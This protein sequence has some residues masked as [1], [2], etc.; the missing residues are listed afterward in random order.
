M[1]LGVPRQHSLFLA[2]CQIVHDLYY[3]GSRVLSVFKLK[4]AP[5]P[6]GRDCWGRVAATGNV[7]QPRGQNGRAADLFRREA[8]GS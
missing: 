5:G 8:P 1:I 3:S 7:K 2:A 4:T 6:R